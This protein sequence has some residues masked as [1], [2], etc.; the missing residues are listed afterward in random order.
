[1]K[2]VFILLLITLLLLTSGI[3]YSKEIDTKLVGKVVVIDPGH[4]G[5]DSGTSVSGIYEKDLNLDISLLLRDELIKSG[6]TVLMTRDG[7][8]DLSSPN[9]SRRKKS[10]F[11]NRINLINDSEADLYLSIHINYLEESK[12]YGAQVFYTGDN[13]LLANIIQKSFNTYLKSPMKEK[14]LSNDIY[15]YKKLNVPG[16][17]IECGFMSNSIER[18]KMQSDEY[19]KLLVDSIIKGLNKYY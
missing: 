8:Y 5:K 12:Y 15:M 17:L 16:V 6:A 3:A 13:G 1:M 18:K 9:V 19:Q 4:G 2:K 14:K 7:D 11:D 10:D